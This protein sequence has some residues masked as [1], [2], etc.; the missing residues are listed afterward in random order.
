MLLQSQKN[1]G[2]LKSQDAFINTLSII[3]CPGFSNHEILL[4]V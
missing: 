2:S 3:S 1:L 4:F